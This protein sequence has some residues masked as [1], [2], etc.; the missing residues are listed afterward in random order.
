MKTGLGIVVTLALGALAGHFLLRENGYVLLNFQGYVVEMSVPVAIF[1]LALAYLALRTLAWVWRAPRRLGEATARARIRWAGRQATRGFIAIAEGRFT[2]GER[3]LTKGARR[4]GAP[5]MNYLAAAR[6]AH[7]QND[8]SRRDGWL[9]LAFEQEPAAADVVLLTQAE[10]QMDDQ[11]FDQALATLNRVHERNPRHGQVLKLLGALHWRRQD[12][13]AL[14]ELLPELRAA[15]MLPAGKLNRWTVDAFSALLARPDLDETAIGKLWD[16]VPKGLRRDPALLRA[17]VGA[18]VRCGEPGVAETEIR[19]ALRDDWDPG[20]I[21]MYGELPLPD[22][23]QQLKSAE[24]FL[25]ERPEDPDLLLV[26]GRLSFRNQLWGKAR[27]YLETS[28]AIRP[29]VETY[30]A[31]GRLFDRI[32]DKDAAAKAWQKGLEMSLQPG[33]AA[34]ITAP[35]SAPAKELTRQAAG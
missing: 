6:L 35:K 2:R 31:L 28:L 27:S 17:R 29:A 33:D 24:A 3:L 8:P 34:R 19:R 26:V 12:W 18:L 13:P 14:K 16:E 25:R 21:L 15:P 1:L 20:L 10:M 4:S 11:A 23:T 5:L 32:G 9:Q 22:A 7:M 30:Q